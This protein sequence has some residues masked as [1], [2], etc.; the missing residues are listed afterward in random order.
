MKK[1]IMILGILISLGAMHVVLGQTN[2]GVIY[3]EV[4]VNMHRRLP[5]DREGMK[6]MIPEFN[7]H[8]DILIFNATESLYKQVD[9]EAEPD[10]EEEGPGRRMVISRPKAEIY[11]NKESGAII[12]MQE[13]IGKKF[14]IHDSLKIIPWKLGNEEKQIMGYACKQATYFNEERQQLMTAWY[15]DQLLPFLGPEGMNTL[16]GTILQLDVNNGERYVTA[17]RMEARQLKA[18][19]IRIPSGGQKATPMEFRKLVD[20]HMKRRGQND[21]III[22]N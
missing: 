11:F 13:F 14:L 20:D 5:P 12:K 10:E 16:P 15:T 22:R 21:N 3:Y 7:V 17:I 2:E 1:I 4:K 19:E 18:G 8:Q 6:E 9:S